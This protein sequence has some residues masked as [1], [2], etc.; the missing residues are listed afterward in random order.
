[1]R[2]TVHIE[3]A[4]FETRIQKDLGYDKINKMA[5]CIMNTLT[6][7]NLKSMDEVNKKLIYIKDNYKVAKWK[8]GRK[9]GKEMIY[10]SNQ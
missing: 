2:L 10:I 7:R 6:M 5:K 4:P 1:M 8:S 3:N 9:Q